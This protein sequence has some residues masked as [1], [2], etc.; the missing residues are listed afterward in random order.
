MT[1]KNLLLK[2]GMALALFLICTMSAL[3]AQPQGVPKV[4]GVWQISTKAHFDAVARAINHGY[5]TSGYQFISEP[6]SWTGEGEY[7]RLTTD[8]GTASDPVTV[9]WGA[10]VPSASY[11]FKGNLEG[12]GFT[13]TVEINRADQVFWAFIGAGLIGI[14]ENATISNVTVAGIINT[15]EGSVGGIAGKITNTSISNCTNLATI[16]AQNKGGI[17]GIVGVFTNSSIVNCQNA[18]TIYAG[19]VAGEAHHLHGSGSTGHGG[20]A[21]VGSGK[22]G[23]DGILR[24]TNIGTVYGLYHVGGIVGR[25]D[26]LVVDCHNAG[27]VSG[28]NHVGGII[29]TDA[30]GTSGPTVTINRCLNTGSIQSHYEEIVKVTNGSQYELGLWDEY[31]GAIIGYTNSFNP[32]YVTNCFYDKQT[33]KGNGTNWVGVGFPYK[34][35]IWGYDTPVQINTNYTFGKLTSEL[36]GTQIT[37]TLGSAWE[38]NSS[39]LYPRLKNTLTTI[40]G[41]RIHEN[42]FKVAASPANWGTTNKA[43]DVTQN[44][45]VSTTNGVAWNRAVGKVNVSGGNVTI[46]SNGYKGYDTLR[47]TNGIYR[48][49]V[50]IYVAVGQNEPTAPVAIVPTILID[51]SGSMPLPRPVKVLI[52]WE[53]ADAMQARVVITSSPISSPNYENIPT[54][55]VIISEPVDNDP[56]DPNVGSF[57]T[58]SPSFIKN[59]TYYYYIWAVSSTGTPS[60]IYKYGTFKPSW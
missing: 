13:V 51:N 53:T 33:C 25:Y 4:G 6:S 44:F 10:H 37:G 19:C 9:I 3:F 56:D 2:A 8:I 60:T 29:G 20:I 47:A 52:Y 46:P 50:T 32:S 17:G 38:S 48:K 39:S 49:D 22:Y 7:F 45:T 30:N 5:W 18:G 11:P 40:N 43:F 14:A 57:S 12:G 36:L 34:P 24:C 16:N 21:G 1:T 28:H 42:L 15:R 23:S 26:A 35:G 54:T 59:T 27:S 41:V 55:G 58:S 31:V